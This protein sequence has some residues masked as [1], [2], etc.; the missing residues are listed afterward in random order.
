MTNHRTTFDPIN[1]TIQAH[2]PGQI[3]RVELYSID[4]QKVFSGNLLSGSGTAQSKLPV[5]KLEGGRYY[6]K[7]SA[8]GSSGILGFDLIK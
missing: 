2:D 6:L 5:T 7:M 3:I 1:Y 4:G 8:G